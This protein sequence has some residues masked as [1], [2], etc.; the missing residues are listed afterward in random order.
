MNRLYFIPFGLPEESPTSIIKR[1][2]LAH[3]CLNSK[4]LSHLIGRVCS[5]RPPLSQA[6]K[7][8]RDIANLF[9]SHKDEFIDGFY[10]PAGDTLKTDLR[11]HGLFTPIKLIR[12]RV[13]AFCSRCSAEGHEHFLKDIKLADYC[14]LHQCSLLRQCNVCGVKL[15]WSSLFTNT[16]KCGAILECTPCSRED[17]TVESR[18]LEIYRTRDEGA[19]RELYR[20]LKELGYTYPSGRTPQEQRELVKAAFSAL[21]NDANGVANYLH[22][23][24]SVYPSIDKNILSAK[25]SRLTPADL[26]RN[27]IQYFLANSSPT[28][29][30]ENLRP[31]REFNLNKSQLAR[32]CKVPKLNS[33]CTE[34][35]SSHQK[36]HKTHLFN[37]DEI[38][39][40][41][42]FISDRQ[43]T[44]TNR[45]TSD[46]ADFY[47]ANETTQMLGISFDYLRELVRA[48]HLKRF[49]P[50]SKAAYRRED[51]CEIHDKFIS[52]ETF[53][54]QLKTTVRK[55]RA[56]V[57]RQL[58]CED[59]LP[60]R[61]AV[62]LY[63]K[64]FVTRTINDIPN[65]NCKPCVRK[66]AM[67]LEILDEYHPSQYLTIPQMAL[68]LKYQLAGIRYY[69]HSNIIPVAARGKY[70][71]WLVTADEVVRFNEKYISASET[72]KLLKI[73]K[74]KTVDFLACHGVTPVKMQSK[75]INVSYLYLRSDVIRTLRTCTSQTPSEHARSLTRSEACLRLGVSNSSFSSLELAGAFVGDSLI[76]ASN[77]F[78]EKDIECFGEHYIRLHHITLFLGCSARNAINFLKKFCI[79]PFCG[80][81]TTRSSVTFYKVS[82]LA[83]FELTPA[84]ARTYHEIYISGK[85]PIPSTHSPI[86]T[87]RVSLV[88]ITDI[89]TVFEISLNSFARLF[90]SSGLVTPLTIKRI[91]Y[92]LKSEANIVND[93]LSSH[94]TYSG[95]DKILGEGVTRRFIASG[96]L[97]LANFSD[98]KLASAKLIR[99]SDITKVGTIKM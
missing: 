93:I 76:P 90:I 36:A 62:H 81:M 24:K 83:L 50:N 21:D 53:A 66:H 6:N 25:I 7:F 85:T 9:N 97:M 78:L 52:A 68:K 41:L 34:W 2:A 51:V 20:I 37:I 14:P 30:A 58:T 77:S 31:E 72:A 13:A 18:L 89:L 71:V 94:Y 42:K 17:C 82:D 98:P 44:S 27:A 57:D 15:K 45:A 87:L 88:P 23:L 60:T 10:S 40:L 43:N 75:P 96:K 80:A 29:P 54:Q 65:Q 63:S 69:V 55:L 61:L 4:S 67:S 74:N 12:L 11:I 70:G 33:Y 73:S 22:F 39:S 86:S 19:L 26:R 1:F 92:L 8:T 35:F 79:H 56:S 84:I 5:A 59:Y 28:F 49:F 3:G 38:H 47:T 99:R 16:C 48:G 32:F 64:S 46:P 95:A 91:K